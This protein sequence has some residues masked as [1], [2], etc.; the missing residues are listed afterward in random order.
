MAFVG[1]RIDYLYL[2]VLDIDKTI[3]PA[4]RNAST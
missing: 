3:L 4:S 2:A 1:I